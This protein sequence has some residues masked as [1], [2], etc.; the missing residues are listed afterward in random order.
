MNVVTAVTINT[1]TAV[2]AAV[3]TIC[4]VLFIVNMI[5]RTLVC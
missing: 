3:V 2:I 1:L 4:D 5:E